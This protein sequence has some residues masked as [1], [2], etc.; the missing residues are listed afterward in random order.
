MQRFPWPSVFC[1]VT[2]QTQTGKAVT[3]SL[4]S[5]PKKKKK[6]LVH[7]YANGLPKHRCVIVTF[8]KRLWITASRTRAVNK[9][10]STSEWE[11]WTHPFA[12][13]L[14]VYNSTNKTQT[15]TQLC[16]LCWEENR[17]C[18]F[19]PSV[20]W[21]SVTVHLYHGISMN[22]QNRRPLNTRQGWSPSVLSP[23]HTLSAPRSYFEP[24]LH[25][26][27]QLPLLLI[28]ALFG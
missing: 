10:E 12:C 11:R 25:V 5:F 16:L 7:Y 2:V 9:L 6:T 28:K 8:H 20:Y 23:E 19:P 15:H 27:S 22:N 24:S 3:E 1:I 26:L 21:L 17:S 18:F 14:A 13:V 4:V